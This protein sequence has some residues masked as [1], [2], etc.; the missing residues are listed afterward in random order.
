MTKV[1]SLAPKKEGFWER[2]LINIPASRWLPEFKY[3]TLQVVAHIASW[4]P[5]IL[6]GIDYF[7][8][9]WTVNPIQYLTFRTGWAAITWLTASL[10]CTPLNTYLGWREVIKLRRPLG[11]YAALYASVHFIIFV[12]IDYG[13]NPGYIYE[14][15]FEKKYALVGFAT[16][17]ILLPMALTSAKGWQKRLGKRWKN[18]HRWVYLAA[19]LAVTHYIWLVKADTRKPLVYAALVGL[20]LLARTPPVK[21]AYAA[22]RVRWAARRKPITP[23]TP[24]PDPTA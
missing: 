12:G 8:G 18:L 17:L 19:I 15:I 21:K 9:L 11:V 13:L 23:A 1:A 2:T 4:I 7:R 22:L 6:I 10:A 3:S 5:A 24:P 16:F 14:A 20:F